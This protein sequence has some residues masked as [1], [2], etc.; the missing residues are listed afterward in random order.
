M[1]LRRVQAQAGA[2][3]QVLVCGPA[4]FSVN[5]FFLFFELRL[6]TL[7]RRGAKILYTRSSIRQGQYSIQQGRIATFKFD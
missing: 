3:G 1:S 5:C 4:R 6:F 7:L 2:G